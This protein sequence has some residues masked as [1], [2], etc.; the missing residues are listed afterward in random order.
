[1]KTYLAKVSLICL[2][3]NWGQA[4]ETEEKIAKV[5]STAGVKRNNENHA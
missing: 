5:Y 3:P 1:M 4:N 2:F